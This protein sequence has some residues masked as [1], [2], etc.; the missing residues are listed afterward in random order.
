MRIIAQ[1]IEA[2]VG[3]SSWSGG[4]RRLVQVRGEATKVLNGEALPKS[5]ISLFCICHLERKGT[6][7][8]NLQLKRD[9]FSH[10]FKTDPSV[11]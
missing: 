2:R 8:V 5:P 3:N 11:L 4:M 10:T 7:S 6:P 9:P 1:A